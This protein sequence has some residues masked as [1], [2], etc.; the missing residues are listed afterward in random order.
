[1]PIIFL[2]IY[3]LLSILSGR[4]NSIA[5]TCS[6]PLT[7]MRYFMRTT[8]FFILTVFIA[9]SSSAQNLAKRLNFEQIG[10]TIVLPENFVVI[11]YA[12]SAKKMARGLKSIE[13]A[14]E[15]KLDISST[16]TLFS[17][18]INTCY[19]DATVTPF[20]S[21]KENYKE[22]SAYSRIML[23][24]TFENKLPGAT[25]D[26]VLTTQ[27][28]DDLTFSK[29]DIN[30]KMDNRTIMTMVLLSKHHRGFN[31]NISYLYTNRRA[32]E[33]IE[34]CLSNSNFEKQ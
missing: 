4:R 16:K 19:F 17:G 32:K 15:M 11:D 34:N 7:V 29:C 10:W 22:S 27:L 21:D 2:F 20:N 28:I 8:L 5:A 1:M 33:E 3:H 23:F 12:E 30:V 6:K 25:V 13:A 26:S 31:I 24:K 14:N 18:R 9:S